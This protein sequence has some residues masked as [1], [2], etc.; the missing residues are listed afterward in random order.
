MR[1][2]RWKANMPIFGIGRAFVIHSESQVAWACNISWK[3]DGNGKGIPIH[4]HDYTAKNKNCAQK[5]QFDLKAR[6]EERVR[7]IEENSKNC[8]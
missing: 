2:W 8:H 5:F 1:V 6:D 3:K 4:W 7:L